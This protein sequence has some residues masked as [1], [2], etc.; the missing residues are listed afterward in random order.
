ML[1]AVAFLCAR[2]RASSGELKTSS[3]RPALVAGITHAV[4]TGGGSEDDRQHGGALGELSAVSVLNRWTGR[5]AGCRP[6]VGK[7]LGFLSGF[8]GPTP[9][10]LLFTVQL[11]GVYFISASYPE[12]MRFLQRQVPLPGAKG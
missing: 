9:A 7:I 10:I 5:S 1:V 11:P 4:G 8:G 12:I 2:D 6:S 3:Q